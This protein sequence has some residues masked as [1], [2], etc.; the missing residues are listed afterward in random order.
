MGRQMKYIYR[1][2]IDIQMGRQ[3]KIYLQKDNR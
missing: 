1:K 2:I 3:M